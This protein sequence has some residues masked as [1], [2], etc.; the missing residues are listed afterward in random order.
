[1]IV[2][3]L[4]ESIKNNFINFSDRLQ[5]MSKSIITMELGSSRENSNLKEFT[6]FY[7][8][9]QMNKYIGGGIKSFRINCWQRKNIQKLGKRCL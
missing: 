4:N 1:M 5:T 3:N 7:G 6:T 2:L 8:T 9:W